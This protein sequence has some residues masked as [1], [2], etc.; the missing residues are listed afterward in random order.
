MYFELTQGT[1]PHS[2][3]ALTAFIV[4]NYHTF[5]NGPWIGKTKDKVT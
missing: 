4:L 1:V 3:I 5:L 2:N